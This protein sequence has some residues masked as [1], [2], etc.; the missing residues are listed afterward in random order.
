VAVA[1]QAFSWRTLACCLKLHLLPSLQL[2]APC[3]RHPRPTMHRCLPGPSVSLPSTARACAFADSACAVPSPALRPTPASD[4]PGSCS[5]TGVTRRAPAGAQARLRSLSRRCALPARPP[6]CCLGGYRHRWGKECS[7]QRGACRAAATGPH[8][9]TQSADA[10]SARSAC[11]V[12]MGV[13]KCLQSVWAGQCALLKPSLAQQEAA[14]TS[15]KRHSST[16]SKLQTSQLLWHYTQEPACN[17]STASKVQA[18]ESACHRRSAP[19]ARP[20]PRRRRPGLPLSAP[21]ATTPR[22][23]RPR[24]PPRRGARR[25]PAG[26]AAQRHPG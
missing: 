10:T 2:Q 17:V 20:P 6:R 15:P 7:R 23:R 14:R 8:A 5:G 25:H 21:P 26:A 24:T 16:H 9:S 13:S 22:R 3:L 11:S 12:T 4:A 18:T 1:G 19:R